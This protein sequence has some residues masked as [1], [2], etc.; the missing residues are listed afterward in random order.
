MTS[1]HMHSGPL[2]RDFISGIIKKKSARGYLEVGVR[3]GAT[4]AMIDCPSIGVD[5]NFQIN[6]NVIGNKS[7]LHLFQMTSDQ[8][9]REH[10]LSKILNSMIDV[11]FLDGLHQFEFLLRD[12]INSEKI[13]HRN[14]LIMLD[15]CLP[16]N[17]EMTERYHQ[18]DARVDRDLATWWTG[19][20]WKLLPI[21]KEYRPD[22]RVTPVDTSPTGNIC[23][24]NLDPGSDVLSDNYYKIVD[25]YINI[26]MND[27][28]F[29][30]FYKEY[31]I[32][33]AEAILYGF[34]ASLFV[35][36]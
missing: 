3:D 4:L 25:E 9:F 1:R 26:D 24:T 12:F 29:Q 30:K 31:K 34:D 7:K 19:D 22:L 6:T 21:L 33:S 36:P 23:I 13:S 18:V 28:S 15:D 35:G 20:V 14:G 2:F 17:A 11:V 8:F 5:P 32:T 10:D 27:E 16:A